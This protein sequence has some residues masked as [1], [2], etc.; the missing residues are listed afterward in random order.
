VN[1]RRRRLWIA[2]A[3]ALLLVVPV[4]SFA[5]AVLKPNSDPIS[6]KATEWA[7]DH[8]LGWLVNRAENYWYSH[9]QPPKGGTP[10]GGL[11]SA[12]QTVAAVR[13]ARHQP[14]PL[15]V[16]PSRIRAIAPTAL[17]NEGVYQPVGRKGSGVCFAYMRPDSVHT[18]VVIGVAWMNMKILRATLH[19][20]TEQPGG[21][22]WQ[23]GPQIAAS[24]YASVAAAFNGGFRL[25]D[26]RGGYYNEQRTVRP[27]RNGAASVVIYRNGNV[28]IGM[29]GRDDHASQ[30]VV[31]V[32]QNLDLLVDGGRLVAGLND[33]NAHQW[34]A[35]LG[36]QIYTW[37]SGV[38]I[39]RHGNLVYVA[40]PGLN[41][42]TLASVLRTAGSVRAMELDINPTWVSL[43][44]FT[45]RA[46]ADIH[47]WKLLSN[48][49][50]PA[51]R[52]LQS[53]TRDFVELDLRSAKPNA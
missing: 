20:G 53:G 19:N 30:S 14:R 22:P 50:R 10:R 52:Y 13:H 45:G 48:M 4:W 29:W 3:I 42:E 39:D 41:V 12:P 1:R 5:S 16:C 32:R 47:G 9:H 2:G 21:G 11:P 28:D 33:A 46:P 25:G 35:T 40:G 36:N 6:A 49:Q 51:D 34:G 8:H 15:P 24:D 18:S 7:R 17:P 26:S 31:S 23:A 43:M 38:G 44:V 27:L 37:R